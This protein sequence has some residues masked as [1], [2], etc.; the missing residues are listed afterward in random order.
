MGYS[1]ILL[2][3]IENGLLFVVS[4]IFKPVTFNLWNQSVNRIRSKVGSVLHNLINIVW[5]NLENW[6]VLNPVLI[7]Q[8]RYNNSRSGVYAFSNGC[9]IF[10]IGGQLIFTVNNYSQ[11]ELA[12]IPPDPVL[13]NLF[14][15]SSQII[16]VLKINRMHVVHKELRGVPSGEY[17]CHR[18]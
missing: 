6:S 9:Y 13:I 16:E 5:G 7:F 1:L 15:D 11:H 18:H 3:L 10:S 17:L 14:M 12:G 2:L 4:E 8:T